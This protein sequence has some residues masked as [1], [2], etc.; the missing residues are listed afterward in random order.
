MSQSHPVIAV[1]GSSG[2]GTSTVKKAFEHIFQREKVSAAVIEGDSFHSL[3]RVEFKAAMAVAEERGNGFLVIL[4]PKRTIFV[5]L[6]LCLRV[7]V[8]QA[9]ECGA[10]IFTMMM[11]P[12]FTVSE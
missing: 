3:N 9:L 8:K 10:T 6:K 1:T 11:K 2:A 4:D 7:M 12:F 5:R